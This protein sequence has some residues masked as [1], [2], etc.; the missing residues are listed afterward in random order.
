[1]ALKKTGISWIFKSFLS[2]FSV[3]AI[4]PKKPHCK[5]L[6]VYVIGTMIFLLAGCDERQNTLILLTSADNPPFESF[7]TQKEIFTGFDIDLAHYIAQRMGLHLVIH[8]LRFDFIL[9][10]LKVNKGHMA[11]SGLNATPERK[12]NIDFSD[13]YIKVLVYQLSIAPDKKAGSTSMRIG[14]QQGS[15]FED[16][17]H[18]YY[19][20]HTNMTIQAYS[21]LNEIVQELENGRLD[22]AWMDKN[23]AL[24]FQKPGLYAQAIDGVAAQP[25][26]IALPKGSPLTP[27]INQI[28]ASLAQ[29]GIIASLEKKWLN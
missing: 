19:R 12:K 26:F 23:A 8:D 27:K 21:R 13:Y 15:V 5:T 10:A 29:Q 3:W 25:L 7:D 6:W 2:V 4:T 1:M 14:V 24:A 17:A 9:P 18:K 11:I 28:L 16:L 20:H 22:R